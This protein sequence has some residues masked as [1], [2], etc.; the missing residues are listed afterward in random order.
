MSELGS[1]VFTGIEI[2]ATA[3]QVWAVWTDFG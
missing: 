1:H 3:D 2:D